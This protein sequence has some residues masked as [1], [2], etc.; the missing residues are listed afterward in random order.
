MIDPDISKIAAIFHDKSRSR[1]LVTLLGGARTTTYLAKSANITIQT[2]SYHL[3]KMASLNFI[4]KVR[5]GKY[6]YYKISN[7]DVVKLIELLMKMSDDPKITSLKESVRSDALKFAR[8]CF[9]HM[10]GKLAVTILDKFISLKFLK[11][12]GES[13]V[14]TPLGYET[15]NKLNI[16]LPLDCSG[17]L[18]NDW[19]EKSIHVSGELGRLLLKNF[20]DLKYVYENSESRELKLTA[21]GKSFL[22]KNFNIEI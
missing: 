12:Y 8:I 19:S 7:E 1:M 14:L 5:L 13:V 22:S 17:S 18:C 20:F 21:N 9:D 16:S 2:A 6:S 10:A 15:L 11:L 4:E 3:N